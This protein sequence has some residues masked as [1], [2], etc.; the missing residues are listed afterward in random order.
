MDKRR[1]FV[2]PT[3]ANYVV[4]YTDGQAVKIPV[5]LE[6]HVDHWLQ[7]EP[8]PLPE[9]TIGWDAPLEGAEAG[10]RATLY[11]MKASNPRPDVAVQSIDVLRSLQLP[12]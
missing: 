1:P 8:R 2:L 11:S 3:V 6:R 9:A 4:H 10:E 7:A 12:L 5:V